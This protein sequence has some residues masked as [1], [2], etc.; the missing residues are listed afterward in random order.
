MNVVV[1][2][3]LEAEFAPLYLLVLL[4][5][6]A[7]DQKSCTYLSLITSEVLGYLIPLC[8]LLC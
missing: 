6:L 1:E 2:V 5:S 8:L 3:G 4:Y 7:T